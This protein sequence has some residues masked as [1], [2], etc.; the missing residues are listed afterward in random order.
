MQYLKDLTAHRNCGSSEHTAKFVV[1]ACTVYPSSTKAG[2]KKQF[3]S[4]RFKTFRRKGMGILKILLHLPCAHTLQFECPVFP[5]SHP[6]STI[7]IVRVSCTSFTQHS[8]YTR[9]TRQPTA[10][11]HKQHLWL[12]W[13]YRVRETV[14]QIKFPLEFSSS[15]VFKQ[16]WER[17]CRSWELW[18]SWAEVKCFW[19][20]DHHDGGNCCRKW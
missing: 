14:L 2:V 6:A 10:V 7:I 8:L 15:E 1:V 13:F 9:F 17:S 12:S 20:V 16:L 3:L 4:G 5:R 11:S 19:L 18:S